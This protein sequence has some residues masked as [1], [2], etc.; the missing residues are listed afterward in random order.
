MADASSNAY[1]KQVDRLLSSSAYGERWASMWLDLARYADSMGYEAD[2]RRMGVWAYRDWVV[3]AYNRN[4]P[5]DQFVTTQLAGDLLPNATFE[6]RIA[7]SF[8]RQTPNNQEGGTD[9]EEFRLVAVMDRV[10]TTWSVLN[11]VTMNCVQCHSHPYDPIRH[12]DYYKSLAFFNTSNDADRDDDFPN[13]HFPKDK[14]RYVEASQMQQEIMRL[15]HSVVSSDRELVN[16][17]EWQPLP[18]KPRALMRLRHSNNAFR[19]MRSIWMNCEKE[20]DTPAQK[21]AAI[22]DQVERIK[23]VR[24]RLAV[25]RARGGPAKT[26]Q[27]RDGE[28]FANPNTPPQSYYELVATTNLP[29]ITAIRVEVAPINA[30]KARHTPE[31]GFVVDRVQATLLKPDGQRERIAF[32][33][34]LQDSEENLEAAVSSLAEAKKEPKNKEVADGFSSNPKLFRTR[35]IVGV[36]AEP[37]R[38]TRETR[39]EISLKQTREIDYKPAPIQRVRLALS[40]EPDVDLSRPGSDSSDGHQSPYG[41]KQETVED[42]CRVRPGYV[43]GGTVSKARYARV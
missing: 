38:A 8:H 6:D 27:I 11:G 33:C 28:V 20:R 12:A 35:W 25:A 24:K 13:L 22:A 4:L 32:R 21:A 29:V 7:T 39:I 37:L 3:E 16:K 10:A 9:D 1:E 23:G 40:G 41:S 36:L 42:S 18:I 31:G 26:F 2:N 5:Y 17:S 34:F 30:E 19:K 43:G 15:L 14:S